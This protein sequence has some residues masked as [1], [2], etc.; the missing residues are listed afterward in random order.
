MARNRIVR[1]WV[2]CASALAV[3]ALAGCAVLDSDTQAKQD[4]YGAAFSDSALGGE[5]DTE[6]EQPF[7][8]GWREDDRD[9]VRAEARAAARAEIQ[10]SRG[11]VPTSATAAPLPSAGSSRGLQA[12]VGVIIPPGSG[13]SGNAYRLLEVL[14]RNARRYGLT[15]VKPDVLADAISQE[16]ACS[17]GSGAACGEALAIYPGVRALLVMNTKPASDGKLIV[18]TRMLDADFGIDYA[19]TTARMQI[20]APDK[21]DASSDL[22]VWSRQVLERTAS[23]VDIA[24]WFAHGF[25]RKNND[26]YVN[27]G[28]RSG[29]DSGSRLAV[30]EEGT[31][32]RAP[33]G[34]I[35]GWDPGPVVGQLEIKQFIGQ[36]VA[37]AEAVSGRLPTPE[38]KLTLAQ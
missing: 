18:Q 15:L 8:E 19:A 37:I 22:S 27:V 24:P 30:H 26:I 25:S 29:L 33:S 7:W 20:T 34:Q 2:G 28:E 5:H 11:V 14:D 35:V 10:Q 1:S 17:S 3:A 6:W 32:V 23:R 31:L 16:P 36:E 12:K 21:T 38:D 9:E 4:K 13:D